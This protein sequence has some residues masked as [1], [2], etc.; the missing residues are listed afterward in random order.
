LS[1]LEDILP[2]LDLLLIMTVNPGFGGQQFIASMLPKLRKDREMISTVAPNV[3]I[4]VDGGINP[5]NIETVARAGADILVAGS[6]VF[7]SGDYAHTLTA[8]HALLKNIP[9]PPLPAT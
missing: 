2:D 5:D 4:E 8:M 3:V 6:A 7:S 1:L 9:D